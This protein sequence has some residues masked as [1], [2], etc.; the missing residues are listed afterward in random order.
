MVWC[1]S[2][3]LSRLFVLPWFHPIG[4]IL[5]RVLMGFARACVV[6]AATWP[7]YS[8]DK[9]KNEASIGQV[10]LWQLAALT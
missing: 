10:G 3:S 7:R 1:G 6:R 5:V 4:Q 2:S 9:S 8:L